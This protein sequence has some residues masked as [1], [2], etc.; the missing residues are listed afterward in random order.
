MRVWRPQA[1]GHYI[2]DLT[3]RHDGVA[4][5]QAAEEVA[6]GVGVLLLPPGRAHEPGVIEVEAELAPA[7]SIRVLNDLN[8]LAQPTAPQGTAGE[9][10]R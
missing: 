10:T 5:S 8:A 3:I 2:A 1:H 4:H 6:D 9:P 7:G